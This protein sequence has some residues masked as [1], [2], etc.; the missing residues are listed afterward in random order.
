M[1]VWGSFRY[2]G[3]TYANLSNALW[4]N[5][6]WETFAGVKWNATNKLSFNLGVVNFLNQKVPTVQYPAQNLLV[7]KKPSDSMV[8]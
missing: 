7:R 1:T 2:F 4:F 5:G 8:T 3:K 6:H